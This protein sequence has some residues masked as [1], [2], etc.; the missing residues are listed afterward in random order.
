[1]AYKWRAAIIGAVGLFMA[2]L[3][4][5]IVNVALPQMRI[6]FHTDLSTIQWVSTG[7][8]LAQAAVIPVVGYLSDRIG[9][10]IVFLSA[11]SLFTVGSALC[12]FAPNE[13][14]LIAF[15]VVQG[16]GGGALFPVVFALVFRV[17]PPAERGPASSVIGVPVLLAPVFGPT[18][19]GYLTQQF[20]WHAI[21]AVNLPIGVVVFLF[22]IFNLQGRAKEFAAGSGLVQD[23]KGFDVVGLVLAMVGTTSLVYGITQSATAAN[24]LSDQGVWP[25]LAAGGVLL[26]SFVL[27]ELRAKDPVM[28]VR[29]FTNYTFAV[30]NM[31]TWALSAFLFGS[32]LLL[33]FFFETVQGK[34]PLET[35]LIFISQGVGS[36]VGVITAGL[37]YNR[38]GPRAIVVAGLVLVAVASYGF[39]SLDVNTSSQTLQLWLVFRG[40]GLGLTNIP[41]QTLTLSRISNQAM[42]RAS[43]LVNVTRQIFS[44]VGITVLTTYLTHQLTSHTTSAATAFLA[45]PAG[46]EVKF[47]CVAQAGTPPNPA[48]IQACIQHSSALRTY[49]FQ[50]AAVSGL[51]DTFWLVIVGTGA[52]AVLGLFVGRD[53]NVQKL[54]AAKARGE[55]VEARPVV[56]GE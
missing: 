35:G 21:F 42:N 20:D 38:T 27:Y 19:G 15:R 44:A 49:V 33:P 37:L 6:Y 18:I 14:A 25:F 23:K 54:K 5:T 26:V 11:L 46:T 4:N 30:S 36:I 41:L 47:D 51:N 17:F 56:I 28:D 9:S 16:I 22:A 31:L 10:K 3:D 12:I 50:Y 34:G 55:T 32:L 7:Y 52:A 53:P 1:M 40:L 24:G 48:F 43:S 45:S 39:T 13:G 29:L 2:V 8:F